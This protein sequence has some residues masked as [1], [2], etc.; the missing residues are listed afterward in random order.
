MRRSRVWGPGVT[1][2]SNV[3]W[4]SRVPTLV[5]STVTSNWPRQSSMPRAG[6]VRRRVAATRGRLAGG[7]EGGAGQK[8]AGG[9]DEAGSGDH[10]GLVGFGAAPVAVA[11]HQLEGADRDDAAGGVDQLADDRGAL[12][13]QV[14]V[15]EH[16]GLGAGVQ[17][18]PAD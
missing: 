16:P 5:P 14:D 15:G 13:V 3:S 9:G 6:R 17:E 11:V 8:G 10:G 2:V 1:G 4:R 12:D 7:G 18:D